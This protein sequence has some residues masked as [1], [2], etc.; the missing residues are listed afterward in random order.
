VAE[1]EVGRIPVAD[2]VALAVHRWRG[3]TD[4]APFL[5]VH[6]LASNLRMWDGVAEGLAAAGHPVSAVDLRGH[7]RSDKPDEGYDFATVSSDLAAVVAALGYDRP[8]VVGQS[9]GGNVV[10]DLAARRLVGLRGIA[11][12][13]GGWIDLRR[14]ERWEDCEKAM[15]PP[16]I[17]GMPAEDFEA[18]IRGRRSDWPESGIQGSLACFEVRA[19]GTVAP[20]LTYERHLRI[21]RAMWEQRVDE[22]FPAVDVPVLLL[23]CAD[24]GTPE[25][26]ARKRGEVA[27]AEAGLPVSRTVWFA[28]SHDVHAQKPAEVVDVLLGAVADGFFLP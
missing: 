16:R 23:P 8:V 18:M 4:R 20:W 5:L 15:A 22:L 12:V 25:W 27:V 10:V 19:D 7:G 3:R 26:E 13:D 9:W 11:C 2:G 21:L 14:F 17:A 6:G 1:R 28:A 24:G